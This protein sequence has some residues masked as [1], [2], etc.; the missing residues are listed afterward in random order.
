MQ[1]Q[2][3]IFE[4]HEIRRAYDEANETWWFSVMDIIQ[5]LTQQP[6]Y[7]AARNIGR[8]SR[9]AWPRRAVNW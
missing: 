6:D 7:Q 3:A 9:A 2:P 8:C 5:V 4:S 1:N